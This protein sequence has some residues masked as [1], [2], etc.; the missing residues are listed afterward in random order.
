MK[1]LNS[2]RL[3]RNVSRMKWNRWWTTGLALII[4]AGGGGGYWWWS[5]QQVQKPLQAALQ[6]T[7]VRKGNLES[8]ISG[9]G[10]IET[11]YRET[12]KAS[13]SGKIAEI[14]V[15]QGDKV[16]KGQTLASFEQDDSSDSRETQI[17]SKQLDLKKKQLDLDNLQKQFKGA[18][19]DDK[20]AELSISIQK[21]QLDIESTKEDIAALQEETDDELDPIVAPIDGTLATF[22]LTVGDSVGGQGGS[23]ASSLGEV[24]DYDQLQI[25]VGVDELDISKVKLGQSANILV[26]ALPDQKFTGKVTDIAQ[27]GKATSGV[28]TFDVTIMLDDVTNLKAGMSAEATIIVDQKADALYLPIEA[29]QS[30]GNL[31]F[32]MVPDAEGTGSAESPTQ[33]GRENFSAAGGEAGNGRGAGTPG[34]EAAVPGEGT[35]LSGRGAATGNSNRQNRMAAAGMQSGVKRVAVEVGI[36]NEDFIEIVSGLQEGQEVVVPTAAAGSSSQNAFGGAGFGAGGFG[37][38]GFGGGG[39]APGGAGGFS[40]GGGFAPGGNGGANRGTGGAVNRSAG[41]GAQG[42]GAR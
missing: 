34:G 26:E 20:R 18:S 8:A 31:Y 37:G 19:D 11:A 30:L 36:H 9:T 12:L 38:G 27:E 33:P 22:S 4:V 29:V 25:V 6:T 23:S 28:A 24:V 21:Q 1:P 42:G 3:R 15:K 17:R 14:N 7:P 16:K 40:G 5:H 35:G 10:N 39:I 2:T 41:S 13:S 32:V